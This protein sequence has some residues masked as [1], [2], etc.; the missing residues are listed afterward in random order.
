[1]VR[2][3]YHGQ[4]EILSDWTIMIRLN[5]HGQ[6]VNYHDQTMNYHGQTEIWS[7]WNIVRLNYHGQTE[8]SFMVRLWTIMIRLNYHGQTVN[9]HDRSSTCMKGPI[10][11]NYYM[12]SVYWT[13]VVCLWNLGYKYSNVFT[14]PKKCYG[15]QFLVCLGLKY[16]W[17]QAQ[18]HWQLISE[19]TQSNTTLLT[20]FNMLIV[21]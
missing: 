1:M 11:F 5:Y 4:P 16:S 18:L 3:N 7:D 20:K 17:R 12:R 21:M 2:L 6:T 10:V 8:L 9:Y 19:N 13:I 14:L 15:G